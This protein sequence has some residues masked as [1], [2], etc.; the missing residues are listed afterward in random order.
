V[1][2]SEGSVISAIAR[3][4]AGSQ[5]KQEQIYEETLKNQ[6]IL[7]AEG[8]NLD[9]LCYWIE[10]SEGS[11]A[12]GFVIA[13]NP[14]NSPITVSRNDI[15]SHPD[16]EN[17]YQVIIP[18]Q[19]S[20][21]ISP[22]VR[23]PLA[24]EA[25]QEGENYNLSTGERLVALEYPNLIIRV[26]NGVTLDG[27]L[28][29]AIQNGSLRETDESFRLRG[30]ESAQKK[31]APTKDW[32]EHQLL[33]LAQV[34]NVQV[35][36]VGGGLVQIL[37]D[38]SLDSDLKAIENKVKSFIPFGIEVSAI[39]ANLVRFPIKVTILSDQIFDQSTFSE[40][41]KAIVFDYARKVRPKESFNPK[42]LE[43]RL[44]SLTVSVQVDAPTNSIPIDDSDLISPDTVDI[45]YVAK[46]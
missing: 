44:K 12:R 46:L 1:D 4:L 27:K 23:T 36:T 20:L 32:I 26:G 17:L 10:R 30:I 14:S 22:R 24:I 34:N 43:R 35:D 13:E 18:S 8:Q 42:G 37:T 19:P 7:T 41:V 5:V 45:T 6:S 9:D 21:T 11:K 16:T 28:C 31:S 29:G 33:S 40:R 38:Q 2:L 15:I 39:P 25:R 3:S